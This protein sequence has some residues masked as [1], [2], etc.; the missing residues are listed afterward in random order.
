MAGSI[1]DVTRRKLAEEQLL[2]D[3]MHDALTGLPNRVLLMDRLRTALNRF[4]RDPS[5]LFAILFFDLD[6]FKNHKRQSWSS[7]G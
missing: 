6:R 7:R 4:L 1:T 3:A 2:H 5:R